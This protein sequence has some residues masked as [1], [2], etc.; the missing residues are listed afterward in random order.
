MVIDGTELVSVVIPA[1]NAARFLSEAV[2]SV[3]A[4]DYSRIEV[5]IVDDGSTDDTWEIANQIAI[6]NGRVCCVQQANGGISSAR[7]TGIRNCTGE[8]LAFLD[9]DDLWTSDR[10]EKQFLAA[11]RFPDADYFTG[12][13]HQFLD[14]SC[15]ST[16]TVAEELS[17]GAV[18]GTLLIPTER[19]HDVGWFDTQLKVAEFLDWHSRCSELGLHG[20]T[21][22]SVLLQRRIHDTN[23]GKLQRDSRRDYLLAMKSHLD[24]KR[25]GENG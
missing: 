3:E 18:A 10:L 7:N 1:F 4:Q 17:D 25:R 2:A 15:Q 12:Q 16:A 5:V 6:R 13:V 14:S 19:F 21:V 11:A 22:D 9:A 24:R 8:L 20:H 23:T